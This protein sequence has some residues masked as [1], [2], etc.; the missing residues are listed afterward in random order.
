MLY[1]LHRVP[2]QLISSNPS[3][4]ALI[5]RGISLIAWNSLAEIILNVRD[6]LALGI[7]RSLSFFFV[8]RD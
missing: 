8:Q 4:C 6:R 7:I 2:F 3:K 5:K 1:A